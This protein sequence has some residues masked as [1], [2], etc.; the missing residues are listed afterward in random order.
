MSVIVVKTE[1]VVRKSLDAQFAVGL[2]FIRFL[3]SASFTTASSFRCNGNF[4]TWSGNSC[5]N[6]LYI[7][8]QLLL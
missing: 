6:N 1:G 3:I 4:F 5:K 7:Q 2:G 8:V